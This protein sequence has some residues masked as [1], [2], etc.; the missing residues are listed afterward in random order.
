[1]NEGI[2]IKK[3]LQELKKRNAL[4]EEFDAWF[5]RNAE[6]RQRLLEKMERIL[7]GEMK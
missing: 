1:M 5:K 4:P 3:E 6:Y 7:R 2:E